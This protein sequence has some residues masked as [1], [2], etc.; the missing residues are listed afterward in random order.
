MAKVSAEEAAMTGEIVSTVHVEKTI[1]T[2]QA[3]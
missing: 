1:Q 2:I 3:K